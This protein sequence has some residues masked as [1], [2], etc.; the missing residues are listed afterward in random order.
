[1]FL[2]GVSLEV[3][4]R[5]SVGAA[6]FEDLAGLGEPTSKGRSAQASREPQNQR[7]QSCDQPWCNVGEND[8]R[9]TLWA[10]WRVTTTLPD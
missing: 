8:I 4:A 3:P 1:M 2:A 6:V 9:R 10:L 5:M 7:P